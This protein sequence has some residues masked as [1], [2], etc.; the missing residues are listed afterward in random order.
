[1][2]YLTATTDLIEVVT[3]TTAALDV[4][5]NYI[6]AASST[7]VP[8]GAGRQNSAISSIT[9]TTVLSAP[10][11]S[12]TRT[13]KQ[14]TIRNKSTT[15]ANTVTL[16]FDQNTVQYEIY[17]TTLEPGAELIYIEGLGFNVYAT[18][19]SDRLLTSS[20]SGWTQRILMP[21]LAHHGTI[22][23]FVMISG[24][25]YFAY[26]G[27]V[28]TSITPKFV[29][30]YVTGAGAGAQTAEVALYSTPTS[31]NKSAQT[32]TR[33]TST[34]TVDSLTTTGVKRNTSAFSTAVSAGTHL[35]AAMRTAMAT[36]QPT[37][38][39]VASDLS[40]G[41]ILTTTGGGAL[42]GVASASGSLVAAAT[43]TTCPYL[44]VTLD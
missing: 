10:G 20:E 4:Q 26:V 1:M 8:S 3:T 36:T 23:T 21:P 28:A 9:T 7:L 19:T 6:D 41:S 38:G 32:L 14:L 35:W 42:T 17:A 5:V 22:H 2:I 15:T 43:A 44:S 12:T 34:G 31:P 24:T 40:Q 29:E 39:G 33:I 18:S 27:R 11:A 13:L 16:Q 37:C 30:F 25:A